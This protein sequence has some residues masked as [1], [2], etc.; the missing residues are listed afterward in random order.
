MEQDGL[1]CGR[2]L[3][4]YSIAIAGLIVPHE[5]Y[6]QSPAGRLWA[7]G[8]D[9]V[10]VV[11]PSEEALDSAKARQLITVVER[12][13][14]IAGLP[15]NI[16]AG[17][18]LTISLAAE[19]IPG[20]EGRAFPVSRL[21]VIPFD[22][23]VNWSQEKLTRIIR[24]ELAHIGLATFLDYAQTPIW[25]TEGFAE[26]A[27]G[28]MTCLARVRIN[29]D[30]RIRRS[31]GRSPPRIA[32]L[33]RTRLSYD[34]ATTFFQFLDKAENGVVVKGAL[35]KNVRDHGVVDGIAV[36][37]GTDLESL[38]ARWWSYLSDR[39]G[40]VLDDLTCK[41]YSS[42]RLSRS[43]S[44]QGVCVSMAIENVALRGQRRGGSGATGAGQP[45]KCPAT[46]MRPALRKQDVQYVFGSRSDGSP[47][48]ARRGGAFGSCC[49]GC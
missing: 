6:T 19:A 30:S 31:Q 25:F 43:S 44:M 26:W 36:A 15:P 22:N 8:N 33:S 28:E 45:A 23:S 20:V 17:R 16:L 47:W 46:V 3:L 9:R 1:D 41:K 4:V 27:A 37:T 11:F 14:S 49:P 48:R 40:G 13:S 39:Y 5:G 2:R 7:M 10:R 24:H 34:Y 12:H 21:I 42:V 18:R 38:E 29:I 32:M 35:L